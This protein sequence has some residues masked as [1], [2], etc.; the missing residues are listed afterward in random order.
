MTDQQLAGPRGPLAHVLATRGGVADGHPVRLEHR[1]A[2]I[3]TLGK[4][5]ELEHLIMLQYLYAAF[6][7]KQTE[8]E[9]LSAAGVA[10]GA[11]W[12][13]T[14]IG[15]AEQEML[16]LALVQ[17]LLTAVGGRPA[18]RPAELPDAGLPL[19]GRRAG[20]AAPVR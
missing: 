3:Y 7:I 1:E 11:R 15:I 20:R 4:A 2:L 6:S 14:L 19:P 16:H 12:R 18:P 8:A 5:A 17:N 13:R 10:A 9:G